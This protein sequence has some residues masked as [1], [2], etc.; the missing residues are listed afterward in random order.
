MMRG[1]VIDMNDAH[2]YTL[3]QV[4]GILKGAVAIG[5]SVAPNERYDFSFRA[6][7]APA[8]NNQPGYLRVASAHQ[9]DQ[10]GIKGFYYIHVVDCVTQF[11]AVAHLRAHQR[12][13]PNPGIRSPAIE[14]PFLTQRISRGQWLGIYQ[15]AC[16]QVAPQVARREA[17]QITPAPQQ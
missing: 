7:S 15:P 16:G 6:R 5:F 14:F 13:V 11:E 4:K 3:D 1:M 8:P 10:D 9:G 2:L 12:G 17:N